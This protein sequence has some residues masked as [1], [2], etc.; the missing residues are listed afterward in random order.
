MRI[1][2]FSHCTI[3]EIK[4]GENSYELAGGP[5]FYCSL[6]AR[7]M[8][9]DVQLCT[10][11]GPNY[12]Y[13]GV[14]EKNKITVAG[15]SSKM[16]TTRFVLEI[17]GTERTLWIKD[18]CEQI[19]YE[20][21]DADGIL[22]SPVFDEVSQ[23]TLNKI[24]KDSRMVFLDPQ[25]FLRRKDSQG[26]VFF[27]R[28]DM[29]LSNISVVKAD[30]QEAYCLTGMQGFDGALALHKKVEHVLYT[31]KRDVSMLYKNKEYSIRLP[32]MEI[33]DTVGVGDIFT[34]TFCCTLLKEKDAL[35]ALSF[36]GGA[37]QA[38]LESKEVGIDKIPPRGAT[39]ANGA[40]F[41]NTIKFRDV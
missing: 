18:V 16:P 2:I 19:I 12:P 27:E 17:S 7:N 21:V 29:E 8:G 32:S 28:T 40:Y 33:Y 14:F 22:V 25:G 37:A 31:N 26:K 36:A 35:W 20:K 1:G 4:I 24:Q 15:A 9:F 6:A 10:K 5:A 13:A 3:D 23:P 34:S 41:Y 30:P 11:F 38:A 39:E